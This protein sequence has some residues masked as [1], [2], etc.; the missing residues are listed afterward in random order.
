MDSPPSEPDKGL[1]QRSALATAA[2]AGTEL[3]VWVG[4]AVYAGRKADAKLGTEPWLLL[5]SALLG[6]SFGLY[7]F[8]RETAIRPNGPS[9]RS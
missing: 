1:S 6:I 4:L 3:V 9:K 7:R 5:A 8:L 2:G